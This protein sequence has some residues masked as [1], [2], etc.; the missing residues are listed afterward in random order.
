MTRAKRLTFS[1][2]H[3]E[4]VKEPVDVEYREVDLGP[5]STERLPEEAYEQA[6]HVPAM[7]FARNEDK[8]PIDC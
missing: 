5:S 2:F 8:R 4:W 3:F 6:K 7:G 1:L